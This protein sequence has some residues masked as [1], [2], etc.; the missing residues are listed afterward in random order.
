MLLIKFMNRLLLKIAITL[1]GFIFICEKVGIEPSQVVI[2]V[3]QS[4]STFQEFKG[5]VDD[6]KDEQ[7]ILRIF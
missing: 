3:K 7:D 2:Q 6:L 4:I 1:L 5:I